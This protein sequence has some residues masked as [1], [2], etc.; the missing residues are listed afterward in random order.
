MR[1][2]VP[3]DGFVWHS[4]TPVRRRRWPVVVG[5]LGLAG[6]CFGAG[7]F[8]A[9]AFA[10][11]R[12]PTPATVSVVVPE[13]APLAPVRLSATPA[14][15]PPALENNAPS[16]DAAKLPA[17]PAPAAPSQSVKLLNPDADDDDEPDAAESPKPRSRSAVQAEAKRTA[18][19]RAARVEL[20]QSPPPSPAPRPR[21]AGWGETGP[22]G[23]SALR[24]S[25]FDR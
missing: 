17:V 24:E 9:G 6:I 13:P 15:T 18:R 16:A 19:S 20:Q 21:S 23:Y 5:V 11:S 10:P 22:A 1:Y 25:L 4:D 12:S 7:L 14:G 2:H 3:R 8:A